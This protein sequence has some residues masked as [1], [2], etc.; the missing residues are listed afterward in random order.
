MTVSSD[1]FGEILRGEMTKIE[2]K[3]VNLEEQVKVKNSSLRVTQ[4]EQE[5]D[6]LNKIRSILVQ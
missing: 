6:V 5:T 2:Q 1:F 4:K 3:I